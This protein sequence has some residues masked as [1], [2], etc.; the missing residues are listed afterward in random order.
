[1]AE[2][3]RDAAADFVYRELDPVHVKGK[4]KPVV[5]FEPMGWVA[6]VDQAT[7]DEL[8]IFHEM[9]RFYRRQNLEPSRI[10]TDEFAVA[11]APDGVV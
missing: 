11:L 10:A 8:K 3:T 4:D 1:M 6:G 2:N 7:R 9:R 5:I